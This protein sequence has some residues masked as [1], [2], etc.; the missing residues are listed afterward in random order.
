MACLGEQS[1]DRFLQN[2]VFVGSGPAVIKSH[3]LGPVALEWIG[4]GRA[5]AVC[6]FRDPRD[7]VASDIPFWGQ[8]FEASVQRV[9]TSL[10]ALHASYQASKHTLFIRYE[11]M[12][13]DR[14]LQICRIAQFLGIPLSE[15]EVNSIDDQTNIDITQRFCQSITRRPVGQTDPVLGN[16]RRDR[17]TLLHDNH[18]GSA[19]PGRWKDDLSA[20]QARFLTQLF[21]PSLRAMGYEG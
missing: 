1:L 12:M 11:E 9:V 13:R 4:D 7:C 2:A 17:L 14:Q 3:E 20:E 15:A 16:H 8:G 19:K 6:T 18:I 10:K 21:E 5:K